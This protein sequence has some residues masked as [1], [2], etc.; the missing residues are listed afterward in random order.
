MSPTNLQLR[1]VASQSGP[2]AWCYWWSCWHDWG[3]YSDP[4]GN[5]QCTCGRSPENWSP[6]AENGQSMSIISISCPI[7]C[8]WFYH[9]QHHPAW[10]FPIQPLGR[11]NKDSVF[12]QLE[13]ITEGSSLWEDIRQAGHDPLSGRKVMIQ[14]LP[15]LA[16]SQ[17]SS[18]SVR[19][20]WTSHVESAS[21]DPPTGRS[22]RTFL[23]KLVTCQRPE[24]RQ[25][26]SV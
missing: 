26:I 10:N 9:E 25:M 13:I 16:A 17:S 3:Q 14:T 8:C 12:K 22:A 11:G 19:N 5:H 1:Q 15:N 20:L 23:L 18:F 6:E 7:N 4:L 2:P 24:M 21:K